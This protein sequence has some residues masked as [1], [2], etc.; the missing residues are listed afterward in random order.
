MATT[1]NGKTTLS[2][3]EARQGKELGVMRYVLQI[4]LGLAVVAGIVIYTI[5]FH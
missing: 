5:F 1:E 4:S 2:A 3:Q